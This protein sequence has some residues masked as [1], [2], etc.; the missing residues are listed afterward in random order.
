MKDLINKEFIWCEEAMVVDEILLGGYKCVARS[1]DTDMVK[2]FDCSY[3][4]EL[5]EKQVKQKL[6]EETKCA[7]CGDNLKE[8]YQVKVYEMQSHSYDP[9]SMKHKKCCSL[10]C[11]NALKEKNYRIYKSLADEINNQVVQRI[12]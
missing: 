12:K 3:V 7:L 2:H 9:V 10:E 11:A 5:I 6:D 4:E 8:E 1:L